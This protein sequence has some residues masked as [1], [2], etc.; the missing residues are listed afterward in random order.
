MS[1]DIQEIAKTG[2]DGISLVA[3]W[4]AVAGVLPPLAAL[5]SLIWTGIRI[6]EWSKGKKID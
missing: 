3:A 4:S 5:A 2:V 1:D 6:W